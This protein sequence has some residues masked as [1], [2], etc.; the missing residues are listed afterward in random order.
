MVC[1]YV[2][3]I[4]LCFL[5]AKIVKIRGFSVTLCKKDT[6]GGSY[7]FSCPL[8]WL[9]KCLVLLFYVPHKG[10]QAQLRCLFVNGLNVF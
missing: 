1:V 4:A 8:L 5:H 7:F 3:V 2:L 6:I 9:V 10:T